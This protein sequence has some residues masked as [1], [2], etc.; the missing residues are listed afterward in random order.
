VVDDASAAVETS[1]QEAIDTSGI[2]DDGRA[3]NDPRVAPVPITRVAVASLNLTLFSEV[4]A[5]DAEA[6]VSNAPRAAN[7]PRGPKAGDS[8][9]TESEAEEA[10]TSSDIAADA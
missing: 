4:V 5:P 9:I 6:I 7:D 1:A 3:V 10:L 8:S 2:G